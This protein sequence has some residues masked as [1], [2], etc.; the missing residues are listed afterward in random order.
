MA[1]LHC[2]TRD[3]DWSQDDFWTRRYNPITK[4][5]SD[6]NWLWKP[7]W[8]SF[9]EWMLNDL[10]AIVPVWTKHHRCGQVFIHSWNML[11]VE[12]LKEVRVAFGMRWW[13]WEAWKKA[14]TPHCPVCHK[15]N[16]DVD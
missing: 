2:H 12:A 11:L 10:R 9:D 4:L 5:W 7:R 15:R 6:I 16:F 3:C 1:Y 14:K 13:T 8:I